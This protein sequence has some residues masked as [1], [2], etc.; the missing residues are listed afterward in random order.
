VKIEIPKDLALAEN[1]KELGYSPIP[2][3]SVSWITGACFA[4][5]DVIEVRA[6]IKFPEHYVCFR[7]AGSTDRKTDIESCD[8]NVSEGPNADIRLSS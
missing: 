1:F 7:P 4:V 8:L 3:G 5:H 6:C 2:C